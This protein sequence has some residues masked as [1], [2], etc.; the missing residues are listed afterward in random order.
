MKSVFKVCIYLLGLFQLTSCVNELIPEKNGYKPSVVIWCILSPDSNI[1]VISSGNRGINPSDVV[2]ISSIDFFLFEDSVKVA[3]LFSQTI[4]SDQQ[5]HVFNYKPKANKKYALRV[6]N[7]TYDISSTVKMVYALPKV[8]SIEISKGDNAYLRYNLSDQFGE[9]DAYQ[10]DVNIYNI[11]NLIDTSTN[12]II[13]TNFAFKKRF[14]KYDEPSL[15]YN[16]PILNPTEQAD[17]T[18]PVSDDLF[19]GKKKVFLFI[20]SNPV[21]KSILIPRNSLASAAVSDE[22]TAN[23]RFAVIKC[24]KISPEFYKFYTSEN[25]N[26]SIFGTPYFNPTNVFTNIQGGLGLMASYAERV[27]TVWIIK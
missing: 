4:K 3:T 14:D 2:N 18:F 19:D 20:V 27:D 6:F 10:F 24:R 12:S 11:G 1:T 25:N 7:Q 8:D 21:S 26:N 16:F 17:F 15:N 23:K 9:D 5:F 13:Q 22:L